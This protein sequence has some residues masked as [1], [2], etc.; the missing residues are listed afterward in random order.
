MQKVYAFACN[1]LVCSNST[2]FYFYLNESQDLYEN[3]SGMNLTYRL[4]VYR[5]PKINYLVTVP[6]VPYY[7]IKTFLK[8]NVTDPDPYTYLVSVNFT[9]IAPNGS[10]ITGI[11]YT[12][13]TVNSDI[14]NSSTHVANVLGVYIYFVNVTNSIEVHL[15]HSGS[16]YTGVTTNLNLPANNNN[17]VSLTENITFNCSARYGGNLTNI[18]LFFNMNK[19]IGWSAYQNKSVSGIQNS[20]TFDV[21]PLI[22]LQNNTFTDSSYQWN[23]LVYGTAGAFAWNATNFTFSG[24][25]LGSY[26]NLTLNA[27]NISLKANDTNQYENSTGT[28][29][30]KVYNATF[31]AD[32]MNISWDEMFGFYNKE[33]PNYMEDETL[34]Y[35][36]GVNMSGNV[37]LLHFN[38][39]SNYENSTHVYD[40]SGNDNNG[41]WYG[42]GRSNST[43]KLGAYS[44]WF[45]GD[46]DYVVND[47]AD[48]LS[49]NSQGSIS[50]WIN[51]DAIGSY[52]LVF[53]SADYASANRYIELFIRDNGK[54]A[55]AQWNADGGTDTHVYGGTILNANQW[56][57]IVITSDGT[58]Y[59]LY[60]NNI[61][62]SL[63]V[64]TGTNNGDWFADTD[65]RDNWAIGA[66][67]Y[68]SGIVNYFNGLIDELAIWNRS[69]E[70]SEILKIYKRGA[71][72]LNISARSCNNPSCTTESFQNFGSNATFTDI[73][74][75][76][77]YQYFQYKLTFASDNANLTPEL[78]TSSVTIGYD[79]FIE[80]IPAITK[81]YPNRTLGESADASNMINF[82]INEPSSQ[83]FNITFTN[84]S[85]LT[86]DW[87]V[88]G[89]NQLAYQN[90]SEFTWSGNYSQAGNYYIIIVNTTNDAGYSYK[91]WNMTVND[92]TPPKLTILSPTSTT[93][94]TN[95]I[96]FN[97]SGN[98]Q[99]DTC[100]YSIDNWVTNTTMVPIN[101]TYFNKSSTVT[102]GT[103]T[104][105][106]FCNDTVNNIN[107]T[108][109]VTFTVDAT[110]S[111]IGFMNPTPANNTNQTKQ[112]FKV[113]V[114]ITESSL[115]E[116]TYNWNGTNYSIYNDSLVLMMNF[117]NVSA[118]GEK[119]YGTDNQ[120]TD[121]SKY[122]NNGTLYGP[123]WNKTGRYGGAF[124]FDGND[125]YVHRSS[126]NLHIANDWTVSTWYKQTTGVIFK[127][128]WQIGDSLSN[129][130]PNAFKMVSNYIYI[131]DNSGSY[132]KY[133]TDI[134]TFTNRW[135][136]LVVT[137]DGNNLRIHQNG[138]DITDSLTKS[139][140]DAGTMANTNR[141]LWIGVD[142]NDGGSIASAFNGSI[143]EVRIWNRSLTQ[144]EIQ[145][146]YISNLKKY[147]T[148]NWSLYVNQSLNSS[149]ILPDGSY[150]YKAFAED[151]AGNLN[152]TET[153]TITIDTTPPKL[154]IIS[155]TATLYNTNRI[156]F[157]ISANEQLDSCHYSIDNWVTNV[158]M[159]YVNTTYFNKSSV[160]SDG[161]YTAKFFCNDTVN[162]INM[163]GQVTFTIDTTPSWIGFK[164]PTPANNTNQTQQ[165]FKVNVSIT[166]PSLKDVIYNWNGTNYT[167]YNDSLILMYNFDNIS[168]LG[169]DDKYIV[170]IKNNIYNLTAQDNA[171]FNVTGRYG[172]SFQFDGDGD[173]VRKATSDFA[174]SDEKGT[175]SIWTKPSSFPSINYIFCSSDETGDT[176]FIT[177]GLN[178]T[179]HLKI[180]QKND[181]TTDEI[182]SIASVNL[183]EWSHLVYVSNG[184]K[185]KLYLNGIEQVLRVNAGSNTGDWFA[186]SS[187]RDNLV[188]GG[189]LRS[190][191]I[192][193]FNGSIDELRIWN[194]SLSTSE[195]QILYM[196]NLKKY[197]T[198]KWE[199]YIN[200]SK[201]S[202]AV[203][204]DGSY[205]Y[206]TYAKDI[207]GNLNQTETR[208][209]T[210]DTKAPTYSNNQT[211]NSAPISNEWI[212]ISVIWTELSP[213]K[214][215]FGNNFSGTWT[216]DTPRS[217]SSGQTISNITKV[218]ASGGTICWRAYANDTA[219]NI[220]LTGMGCILINNSAPGT[221][222]NVSIRDGSSS[223][224]N[225]TI[226]DTHDRL[227]DLRFT[228]SDTDNDGIKVHVC[229]ANSS[230]ERDDNNCTAYGS[231]TSY[232]Q[233]SIVNITN[234]TGLYFNG[235]VKAYYAR[236][237]PEDNSSITSG[238]NGTAYDF[239]FHL[240]NSIP[241]ASALNTTETHSQTP[242]LKWVITDADDG[243]D[244]YWPADTLTAHLRL[245]NSSNVTAYNSSDNA[246]N[247]TYIL[248]TALPWG[249]PGIIYANRT[250]TFTAWATDNNTLANASAYNY[251]T[252]FVL[253]DYLPNITSV[254]VVDTGYFAG[255]CDIGNCNLE[256][257]EGTNTSVAVIVNATDWDGDC[258]SANHKAWL[259][260]CLNTSLGE[261]CD[262]EHPANVDFKWEIDDISAFGT[263]CT[264]Q[265]TANKT[266]ADN[267][268]EFFR[269]PG[270]YKLYINVT[271]QAGKR[272]L[273]GLS[274]SP[275]SN[276]TWSYGTLKAINYSSILTLGDGTVNMDRWNN[277]TTAH[278]MTNYGNDVL[279]MLWNA[280]N[281]TMNSTESWTLNNTDFAIDNDDDQGSDTGSY[282]LTFVYL[283]ATQK[284]FNHS[285]GL[286][287]CTSTSCDNENINETLDTYFHIYPPTGLKAGVYNTTITIT[288][289]A[290]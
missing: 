11:N 43:G 212:N 79:R 38:N 193:P 3:S 270:E 246:N 110:P 148:E 23:C 53:G 7:N 136:N 268:P 216:N 142:T 100:H 171:K 157:N 257:S 213:D 71:I 28:Y 258:S 93:Y 25:D 174:G 9:L 274:L 61:L 191:F 135:T 244:N 208:T 250:I 89:R 228:T 167:F 223:W 102:D 133:Y 248:T 86:I 101:T 70:A 40:W 286:Q 188:L 34:T 18:T 16:F 108:E 78:N 276:G 281:P 163:T 141:A 88:D 134:P 260:L 120:T 137:W 275:K 237:T 272:N 145:I 59:K 201:N 172:G 46:S 245:G 194:R 81:L 279:V 189:L 206:K 84:N 21:N 179:G 20:T 132:F 76:S 121:V 152:Q 190:S 8:A 6:S 159:V 209:I 183:N 117:D 31:K 239:I 83:I 236:L 273:T 33:L 235:P 77:N 231:V 54:V 255:E 224:D 44:G 39:D 113:N 217:Y 26:D 178:G 168:S 111:W 232:A 266:S 118:L 185:I 249:K 41:T 144:N 55:F 104:A 94:T 74:S 123:T 269:L 66:L 254:L 60:V 80:W 170:D 138:A 14:W 284:Y 230:T 150:T 35:S 42:T 211:N 57:H 19:S 103:Y 289:G 222:T 184:T 218:T 65:N 146:L 277:G 278:R 99:L 203:L 243:T 96:E 160:V 87:Y 68:N 127:G 252:T 62:Q 253:Y 283:N 12:N 195:I 196:S 267:T 143:D 82:S 205:T 131:A 73:S 15:S 165:Y 264:F 285:S 1:G 115:K 187:G 181:D 161:T 140:D 220:N 240:N 147:D 210:I 37:L 214:A 125:D 91:T 63:T 109:N 241:L 85:V 17:S 112:Y 4:K 164:N 72:R 261:P 58:V 29:T 97:I 227:L 24:W 124:E 166:E 106:F 234:I 263:T 186:D 158:S 48:F 98:E 130:E 271:S 5:A 154:T 10:E 69:L 90:T 265:F 176:N 75:T 129:N 259:M 114:S 13:G 204:T 173:Y 156:E 180:N 153:R 197:D 27:N 107:M 290:K 67:K 139:V 225:R 200:Q 32:W 116:I 238:V 128:T 221:V 215:W 162:N 192:L 122:G 219:G 151:T 64:Q 155:P 105:K 198:N 233:A 50:T 95:R 229:I 92:T 288:L 169:E 45:D 36:D 177:M 287:V 126:T 30:S 251:S 226:P 47:I 262:D 280:S 247:N 56:N 207:T 22:F 49:S 202:T 2:P 242:T 119:D 282:N 51:I 182:E 52:Y 199:L 175:L 149:D 256:P